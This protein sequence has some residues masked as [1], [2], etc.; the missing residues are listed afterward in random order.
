MKTGCIDLT[1][2]RW[3]SW[4]SID[5][6]ILF[7]QLVAHVVI[8][9]TQTV[10]SKLAECR[11][12]FCVTKTNFTYFLRVVIVKQDLKN[13]EQIWHRFPFGVEKTRPC[14]QPSLVVIKSRDVDTAEV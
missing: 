7:C 2:D 1:K 13:A 10:V 11:V 8:G 9:I 14:N 5:A 6:P 4:F 3:L 12:S